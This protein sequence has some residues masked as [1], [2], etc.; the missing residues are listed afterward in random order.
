MC[1]L[2]HWKELLP[3][4]MGFEPVVTCL[5]CVN[6]ELDTISSSGNKRALFN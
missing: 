3:W 5:T 1:S 2:A 4:Q 6:F